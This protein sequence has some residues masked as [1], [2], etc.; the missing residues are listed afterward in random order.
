MVAGY[1]EFA[2]ESI[3]NSTASI[4]LSLTGGIEQTSIRMAEWTH[5]N[6]IA[7]WPNQ[8]TCHGPV[9]RTIKRIS[10]AV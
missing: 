3:M 2:D 4:G 7:L 5:E 8:H 10:S 9:D 1:A 6:R